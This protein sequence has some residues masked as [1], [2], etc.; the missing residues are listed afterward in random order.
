[1]TG[2]TIR[3]ASRAD[4]ALIAGFNSAMALETE[5]R[6]LDPNLIDPGVAAALADS[7]KGQYWIA[8]M[9]GRP[10]GQIMIT[11]EW[12]D[13][14]NGFM[15]WIQSVYVAPE[16]RR[17]GVFSALYK[18]IEALARNDPQSC[19]IR[20]YVERDNK[21]AQDT[22]LA[23]GMVDPGYLVMETD[24]RSTSDDKED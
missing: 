23:V 9:A 3:D 5:D 21:R 24:F 22:Y 4:A 7:N 8:E 14:R 13:W 10:I 17:A 20:L 19:G 12:S 1:M 2:L 6:V 16:A 11:Y 18:H 15:W